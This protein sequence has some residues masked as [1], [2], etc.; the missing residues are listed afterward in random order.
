[1]RGNK[2]RSGRIFTR[3]AASAIGFIISLLKVIFGRMGLM[4]NANKLLNMG[5]SLLSLSHPVAMGILNITPD[6][7]FHSSR[8]KSISDAIEK[9]G[10]MF[11]AG[12]AIVDVGAAS[13][14]PGADR[15]SPDEELER[16]RYI[17]PELRREL[18]GRYF[19]I[20]TYHAETAAFA[21]EHGFNMINDVS[22]GRFSPSL[23]GLAAKYRV[24]YVLMH[25]QGEPGTMQNAPHYERV[26]PDVF[27]FLIRK[28]AELRA[29]G[30]HDIVLDPGFGFGKN[31]EHNYSLMRQLQQFQLSDM[32]LMVGISRKSMVTKLLKVSAEEALNGSTVLHTWALMNGADILRVHDVKEAVQAIQICQ[33]LKKDVA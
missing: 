28:S 16:L 18:S 13:T 10:A 8:A 11:E 15:I 20:D 12:A 27:D 6:S 29:Q 23:P 25:M 3:K 30:L 5:G 9:A 4:L 14:R 1:M 19:S 33:E 32:P 17:L 26:F 7:F 2:L 21:L 31:P 24:P 22:A